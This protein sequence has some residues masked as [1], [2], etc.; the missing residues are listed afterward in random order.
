MLHGQL[1]M[2]IVVNTSR[3]L[4][5][6]LGLLAVLTGCASGGTR[7]TD[8]TD[9]SVVFGWI[10][11]GDVDANRLHQIQLYQLQPQTETPYWNPKFVKFDGGYLFYAFSFPSGAFKLYQ[12][13]GQQ[14][15]TILCSNTSFSY[16]FGR[17][18]ETASVRVGAPGVYYLGALKLED[19]KTGFFEAGK[20]NVAYADQGP[21]EQQMLEAM[22]SDARDVD[23]LVAQRINDRLLE[24]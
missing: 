15:V 19:V 11:I 5:L 17:Q 22:L 7:V 24:L 1:G 13:S 20:F 4:I 12:V 14:C 23:S 8:F 18:G 2:E 9:R 3:R 16:S 10:D 21:T 6:M